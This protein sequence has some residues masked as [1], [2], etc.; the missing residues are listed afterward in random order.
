MP[1]FNSSNAQINYQ[2]FGDHTKPALVFSN[3]LGT[4]L[5]MWQPQ[6]DALKKTF[7]L[8]VMTL[9]DTAIHLRL[10]VHIHLNNWAQ[11]SFIYW[12]NFM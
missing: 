6:I 12:I 3:S 1:T 9:V 5:S 10:K 7:I 11:M 4:Q 2:T 8:F